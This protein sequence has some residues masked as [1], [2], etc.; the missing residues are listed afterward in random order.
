[1]T[2]VP[3]TS[4][5][6]PAPALS[7][8][9]PRPT[10]WRFLGLALLWIAG[11][12]AGSFVAGFFAGVVLGV[13]RLS[14]I[15]VPPDREPF[16]AWVSGI[17]MLAVLATA[18]YNAP[19]ADLGNEPIRR[20]WLI[21]LLCVPVVLYAAPLTYSI[22][23]GSP[24]ALAFNVGAAWWATG[25]LVLMVIFGAPLIEELF[26]RGWL[27]TGLRA[28]SG[29]LFTG[30]VTSL[31]WLAAHLP[32]GVGRT[33]LLLPLALALPLARAFSGSVRAPI[34]LHVVNNL[35]VIGVPWLAVWQGWLARP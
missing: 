30:T 6:E 8:V 35:V 17:G 32:E 34:I 20:P 33:V 31:L 11:A 4:V 5:D 7:P 29:G 18:A 28:R 9:E 27:W 21:A 12:F 2:A 19:R 10:T 25:P 16:Y 22:M 24:E 26:F 3:G 23:S 15:L 13:T 14:T 1:M